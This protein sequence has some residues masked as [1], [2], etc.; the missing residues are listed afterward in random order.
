MASSRAVPTLAVLSAS[1]LFAVPAW[2]GDPA[3]AREQLKSGYQLAQ[4]GKCEEAIPHFVESM[5]LDVKAITLINLAQCEEKVGKLTDALGHWV[6]ARARA[7]VEGN[8]QIVAEAEKR[9]KALEPRL[10][11]LTITLAKDAPKDAEVTRD[12]VVLGSVSFGVALPVNPGTHVIVVKAPGHKEQRLEV[13][14]GEG[15]LRSVQVTAGPIDPTVKAPPPGGEKS[16]T[17]SLV[18]IGFG[19]GAAGLAVGTITGLMSLGKKSTADSNCPQKDQ[20]N[21]EGLDAVDAGRTL[22]W[23]STV[24]FIVGGVGAAV[25]VYGLVSGGSKSE[26]PRAAIYL[27]PGSAGLRGSF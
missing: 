15:D 10:G 7:Q 6:D 19:V 5:R 12:D 26:S 11:R 13:N 3:A 14:V 4:D 22:G 9:A 16:G 20:C 17:S 27:G 24:G 18:Y 25:G 2:A 23:V 21:Q 8:P 1:L